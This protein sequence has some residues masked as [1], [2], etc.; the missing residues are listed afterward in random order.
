MTTERTDDLWRD[1]FSAVAHVA[2]IVDGRGLVEETTP[3][4]GAAIGRAPDALLGKH[5]ADVLQVSGGYDPI[6]ASLADGVPRAEE[7]VCPPL[8]SPVLL[9]AQP[10]VDGSGTRRL[11][12]TL[13]ESSLPDRRRV[14]Q[15]A[16]LADIGVLAAGFAHEINSPL[17]AISLRAE[18]LLATSRDPTLASVP[19]FARFARSLK[20]ILDDVFRCKAIV[21]ALL[22]YARARPEALHPVDLS[23]IAEQ[24]VGVIRHTAAL[25]GVPLELKKENDVPAWIAGDESQLRQALVAVCRNAIEASSRGAPVVVTTVV[26]DEFAVLIVRDQGRGIAPAI[27]ERIF[28]PFFTTKP[29][30]EGMG[31]GLALCASTVAAH[32]GDI[33]IESEQNRGTEVRLRFPLRKPETAPS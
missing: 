24:A 18:S 10:F 6:A 31:L 7:R 29:A 12:V 25:G 16:R 20:S 8:P 2:F 11:V 30:G 19:A 32:G 14:L 1:A 27:R 21:S 23:Q 9:T 13:S 28:V 17:A 4:F 5:H 26:E 3:A 22:D 33:R 15:A